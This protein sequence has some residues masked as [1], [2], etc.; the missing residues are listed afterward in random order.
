MNLLWDNDLIYDFKFYTFKG[1]V[2]Y[3]LRQE[4]F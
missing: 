1:I 2:N 4:K 3:K